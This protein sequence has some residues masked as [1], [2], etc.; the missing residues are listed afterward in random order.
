MTLAVEVR[1]IVHIPSLDRDALTNVFFG[2][3]DVL[4][5]VEAEVADV[6]DHAVSVD[7]GR[8]IVTIDVTARGDSI[9]NADTLAKSAVLL[10]MK[11]T[12]GSP[13]SADVLRRFALS[14]SSVVEELAEH[15][16]D[17]VSR[18]LVLA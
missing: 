4:T 6:L 2:M 16:V 1:A 5:D 13:S 7:L 18:E 8:N 11:A 14:G 9:E 10:A 15:D 3:G 17:I 12:G